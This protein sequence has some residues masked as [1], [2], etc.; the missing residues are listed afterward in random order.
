M[1]VQIAWI[2]Y[3]ATLKS[4][5]HNVS[6]LDDFSFYSNCR[7]ISIADLAAACGMVWHL[8]VPKPA[9]PSTASMQMQLT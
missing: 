8:V 5:L 9:L 2:S 1:N 7:V 4:H 6:I 3:D